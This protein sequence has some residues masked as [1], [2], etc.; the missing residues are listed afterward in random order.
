M[1]L[2]PDE[3]GRVGRGLTGTP[4]TVCI[5][6]RGVC[7]D[8]GVCEREL[9]IPTAALVMANRSGTGTDPNVARW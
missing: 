9:V 8:L 1:N 4:A 3:A 2:A 6:N 7:M 5:S